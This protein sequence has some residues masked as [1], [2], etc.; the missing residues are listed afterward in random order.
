MVSCRVASA[1]SRP[2]TTLRARLMTPDRVG[3]ACARTAAR[4]GVGVV[5][6]LARLASRYAMCADMVA[7]TA[8]GEHQRGG[9]A[10][11]RPG[12][13]RPPGVGGWLVA[14]WAAGACLLSDVRATAAQPVSGSSDAR[15][16]P[17]APKPGSGPRNST[18]DLEGAI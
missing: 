1:T 17:P 15:H 4:A 6:V 8:V 18:S 12:V 3:S 7:S 10:A 5:V 11:M 16:E 13:G 14:C 9:L 2:T